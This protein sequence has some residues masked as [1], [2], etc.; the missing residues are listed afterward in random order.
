MDLFNKKKIKNL[1]EEN[2]LLEQKI[3]YLEKDNDNLRKIK[4]NLLEFI[5]G[6]NERNNFY[7]GYK[8]TV[9]SIINDDHSL[10]KYQFMEFKELL[11]SFLKTSNGVVEYLPGQNVY[12][13]LSKVKKQFLTFRMSYVEDNRPFY[14]FRFSFFNDDKASC[15]PTYSVSFYWSTVENYHTEDKDIN[16][17][18]NNLIEFC[19]YIINTCNHDDVKVKK[20]KK[21]KK[22][23]KSKK[24]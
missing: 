15:K 16:E 4:G 13:L 10:D 3:K 24:K 12:N 20:E 6:L 5:D 17:Y 19:R 21:V 2:T 1:V 22:A 14:L 11:V 8:D 18:M 9:E 7:L 23:K